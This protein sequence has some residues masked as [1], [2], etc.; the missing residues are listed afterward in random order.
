MLLGFLEV[1]CT[2]FLG[3]KNKFSSF[4]SLEVE[5]PRV[6]ELNVSVDTFLTIYLMIAFRN[7]KV[8]GHSIPSS[9]TQC[10]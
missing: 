6:I 5:K 4:G 8:I 3:A 7:I 10:L 2:A 9:M 1:V